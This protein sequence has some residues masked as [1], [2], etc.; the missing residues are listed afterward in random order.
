MYN[1]S[2]LC[3]QYLKSKKIGPL[4]A[5]ILKTVKVTSSV[6]GHLM[7]VHFVASG[8]GRTMANEIAY[9]KKKNLPQNNKQTEGW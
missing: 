5:S 9:G 6:D 7:N 3:K 2:P 1:I 8:I 4:V